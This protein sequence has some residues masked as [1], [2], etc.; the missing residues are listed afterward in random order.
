MILRILLNIGTLL[1]FFC[2]LASAQL[3]IDQ[4]AIAKSTENLAINLLKGQQQ[5]KIRDFTQNIDEGYQ[6]IYTLQQQ[7]LYDLKQ[8]ESIRKA[9]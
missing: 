1:L 6:A 7:V 8:T 3:V 9:S 4:K 2:N 5:G